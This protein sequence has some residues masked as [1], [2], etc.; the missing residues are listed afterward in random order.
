MTIGTF[1]D[2]PEKIR[3]IREGEFIGS[4]FNL[5]FAGALV[6]FS[7]SWM[8]MLFTVVAS[9]LMILVY[10]YALRSAPAWEK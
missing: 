8:P 4:V 9:G 3:M 5:A 7:K 2:S 6:F 1:V 10:E